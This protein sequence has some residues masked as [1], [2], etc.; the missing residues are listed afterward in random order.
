MWYQE[1]KYDLAVFLSPFQVPIH[2]NLYILFAAYVYTFHGR[3]DVRESVCTY[4]WLVNQNSADGN[5]EKL[6]I[7]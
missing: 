6:Y 7:T 4:V 5:R 3:K 2:D 1:M